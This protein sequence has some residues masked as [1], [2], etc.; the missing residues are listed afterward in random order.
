MLDPTAVRGTLNVRNTGLKPW[1]AD[2]Y[3]L[4]L[5]YYTRQGGL[6][7]AGAFLK[8]IDDFFGNAVKVATAADLE[9]LGLEPEYVGW[10]LSTSLNSGAARVT[11]FEFNLKHSLR[12]LGRWGRSFTV[13]ANGTRLYLQGSAQ[14]NFSSFIPKS[15]NWGVSFNHKRLTLMAKWNYR[16]LDKRNAVPAFGPDAYEYIGARTKLDL[17]VAYQLTARVS[18]AFSAIN[19]TNEPHTFHRYGSETPAYAR[20]FSVTEYGVPFSI[21]IKG[22]Y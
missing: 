3:D 16:G 9:A 10:T 21:G 1:T 5:E 11:G 20:K 14:A 19:I 6:F 18:V 13:F 22:T 17:N 7:S 2:N 12:E 4:S 8:E 15:A